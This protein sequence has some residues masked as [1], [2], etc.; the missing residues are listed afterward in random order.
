VRRMETPRETRSIRRRILAQLATTQPGAAARELAAEHIDAPHAAIATL[1]ARDLVMAC[2]G[3]GRW[4]ARRLFNAAHVDGTRRLG[5]L[6]DRERLELALELR[7][8]WPHEAR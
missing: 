6:T 4:H 8:P 1:E 2:R 5:E 7:K 3:V